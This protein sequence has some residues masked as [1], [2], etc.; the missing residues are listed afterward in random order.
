MPQQLPPCHVPREIRALGRQLPKFA[1][2]LRHRHGAINV[3][4]IG[5]SSTK[6]DGADPAASY[7]NRLNAALALRFPHQSI[8]VLNLGIGGQEAPDEAA[9]FKT[10]VLSK[11]P[12]LVIWQVGTNAAWKDY[13]LDDVQAA[14]FRGIKRLADIPADVILM[15]LQYAPAL[16]SEKTKPATRQMMDLIAAAATTSGVSVFNRYEIMK[17]WNTVSQVPFEQMISNFDGNWLHQ[18]DWSYNCIA[19]ALADAI[20]EAI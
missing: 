8:S 6:G 19:E 10:D 5:S 11:D 14:I 15:N 3:V 1:E 7:P 17:Y 2:A 4:A 20:A 13:F 18:N 9:R 12:A 16:L